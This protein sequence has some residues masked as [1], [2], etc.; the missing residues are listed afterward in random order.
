[1]SE[2]LSHIDQG[3]MTLTFNR[4]DKKNSLTAD[5]YSALAE[6]VAQAATDASVRVL[7]FQGHETVFCAGN[8]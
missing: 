3:V 1:M 6:A 8:D 5:M 2:I 7:V 4:L